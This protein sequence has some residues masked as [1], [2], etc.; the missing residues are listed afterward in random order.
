MNLE[1]ARRAPAAKRVRG[2]RLPHKRTSPGL[3]ESAAWGG[4]YGQGPAVGGGSMTV[5]AGS[6]GRAAGRHVAF[7]NPDRQGGDYLRMR[8]GRFLTGALRRG[9]SASLRSR[10]G[11]G[12]PL[13]YGRGSETPWGAAPST[14]PPKVSC[15]RGRKGGWRSCWRPAGG[16]SGLTT[17]GVSSMQVGTGMGPTISSAYSLGAF[18][19]PLLLNWSLDMLLYHAE[20][21]K[22]RVAEIERE[23]G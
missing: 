4:R 22:T 9:A 12:R 21:V 6:F 1:T 18:P 14:K 19:V 13:P 17:F 23:V 16:R 5:P 10:Y 11:E 3:R 7:P 2:G 20:F 8:Q 15:T